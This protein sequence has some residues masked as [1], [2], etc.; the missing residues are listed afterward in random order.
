LYPQLNDKEIRFL[1]E[2]RASGSDD[3]PV[4]TGY[5]VVYN[6]PSQDL[7]NFIEII[8]PGAFKRCLSSNPDIFCFS[9]HDATKIL[10]RTSAGTLR[11]KD[12][13]RGLG[14]S[15]DVPNTQL[16]ND[17]YES[18]K[19]GDIRGCSFAFS[20]VDEDW[21][22][23]PNG[24]P[25]YI[26]TVSDA[27]LLGEITITAFPAYEATTVAARSL[28][29]DGKPEHMEMRNLQRTLRNHSKD[30]I[31]RTVARQRVK[32]VLDQ[33]AQEEIE[34]QKRMLNASLL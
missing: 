32:A 12:D 5:A 25:Q 24:K 31:E 14:F 27:D 23:N 21:E 1:G 19:R 18:V 22:E 10:G 34:R 29:P 33:I 15:L 13:N 11:L 4:L 6:S 30:A 26:R 20:A 17:T 8:K 7:G 3:K 2:M 28:W 16:G 9:N